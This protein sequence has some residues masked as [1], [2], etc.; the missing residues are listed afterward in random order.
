[1]DT[2]AL[3]KLLV[4]EPGSDIAHASHVEASFVSTSAITHVEASAALTR[5]RKGMRLSGPEFETALQKLE[6]LW[7]PLYIHAVTDRLIHD[8][9]AAA[10][11][12]ALRAYDALHLASLTAFAGRSLTLA[13]WD[14][15]LRS[16]ARE[17][18]VALLPAEL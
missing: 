9:S 1:M 5:M 2:S 15:E 10:K 8:A 18:G 7:N 17:R 12:H 16:A 11:E 6:E 3:I 13:C 4:D 14:L